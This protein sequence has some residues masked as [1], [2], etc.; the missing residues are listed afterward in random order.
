[1]PEEYSFYNLPEKCSLEDYRKSTEN[2][3]RRYSKSDSLV[4][5]YSWGNVSVAGISDI[6]ILFVFRKNPKPLP[7]S[8]R[9]FY[10]LDKKTRY[11]AR[12][13]FVFID[14]D[15]FKK[16][17]HVYP[18]ADFRLLHGKNIEIENISGEEKQ[19]SAIALL[20]DLI[21]RHYPRDFARQAKGNSINVRDTLLRLNS[22]K[23]S[24]SMLESLTKRKNKEWN[25]I[26]NRISELRK[27][28]FDDKDY[29]EVIEL[30]RN[31]LG[32]TIDFVEQFRNFL[33][34]KKLVKIKA[35][36]I[37]Y[38]GIKNKALFVKNWSKEKA[39]N[40]KYSI[41][42]IELAAQLVEYSNF[43][44]LISSYIR[45]NLNKKPECFLKH[46]PV[47]GKRIG[48]LNRQAGLS[49]K[50]RHSDFAAYFDFGYRNGAGINNWV[51]KI[52]DRL[53]F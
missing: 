21:I 24:I 22:L 37:F 11:L 35:S 20:N 28:W 34:E 15:S 47:V 31:A 45:K 25:Y 10:F 8:R 5:I 30:S 4:S 3:V 43:D 13:P 38:S 1:M 52:M 27:D 51:L 29:G 18:D 16:I 9:S 42:P 50:L 53:R 7:F 12:H 48:I 32:I 33:L 36:D 26:L 19:Y 14:E 44:G 41:L 39:I 17:R 2:I 46:S 49:F 23:Y 6:D 40:G